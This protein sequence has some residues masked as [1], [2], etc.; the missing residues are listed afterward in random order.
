[1]KDLNLDFPTETVTEGKIRVVVPKL[2]AFVAE[3]SEYAPSKAPVFYNP[4]MEFNRDVTI[5]AF[6]AFQRQVE[7]EISICEPL[8]G[9]G[10]R[11]VRFATELEGIKKVVSG[12]IN[13]RSARLAAHNVHINGL[14]NLVTVKHK[15]ANRLLADFSAPTRRFD[16]VDIDPFGTPVP[17]LDSAIRALRNRGLLAA[18]ATDMAPLCGVHPKA[19]IRKYGGKPL[20]TEYCQELAVRLLAGCISSIAAR[21]DIGSRVLFSHSRD[22]YIR[23]Y[24]QISYGAQKADESVRN[25]GYVL[26]CFRCLHRETAPNRFEESLDCPECGAKMDY[27]G[28]LWL[29]KIFDSQ[30]VN[31]MEDLNAHTA[32]RN[33]AK[34]S[35]L[36][37]TIM[38][39]AEA[40]PT[41]YVLD[42]ISQKLKL[43]VPSVDSFFQAISKAGYQ[44]APTHFSP[45]GVRT[46]ALALALQ[47]ALKKL[48]TDL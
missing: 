11:G 29:G 31:S 19:C 1:M 26:H 36:L 46:N 15:E 12:D 8:T 27:A 47:Q 6:Q 37:M 4:V 14:E 43:P 21:H 41:Y 30:F 5:L 45:L 16:I 44:A 42:K 3:P 24:S 20:R 22:H 7:R 18:T 38:E 40:P 25:L 39:E 2:R 10:I 33:H 23:L 17:Y 48:V 32:F 34:I 13:M 9:T 28:P 35:R